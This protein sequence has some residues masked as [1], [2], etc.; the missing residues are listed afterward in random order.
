[1][2]LTENVTNAVGIRT[3]AY[4]SDGVY[5]VQLDVINS[6]NI[7]YSVDVTQHAIQDG[8]DITDNIDPKT[9]DY[10]I[11]AILTDDDWDVLNPESFTNPTIK[12]RLDRL[13]NFR[14]QKFVLTY[15][16]QEDEVD[17]VVISSMSKSKAKDTGAGVRLSIGLKK[18]NVATAQTVD[19]PVTKQNDVNAKGQSPKGATGK[20]AVPTAK[21]NESLL[22]SII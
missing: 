14:V 8:A 19:A 11:D 2:P 17:N 20:D 3:R 10:S 1:M 21:K 4:L 12:E 13:D 5:D 15:F 22:K 6:F 7:N 9:E 18:V 16:G